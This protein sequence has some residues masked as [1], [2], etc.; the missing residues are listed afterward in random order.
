MLFIL[1]YLNI[2][3]LPFHNED[4]KKKFFF[5]FSMSCPKPLFLTVV[6]KFIVCRYDA[7]RKLIFFSCIGAL[8]QFHDKYVD[9]KSINPCLVCLVP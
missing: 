9:S 4:E 3:Q 2:T 6:E 7:S 8:L 5:S 1:K